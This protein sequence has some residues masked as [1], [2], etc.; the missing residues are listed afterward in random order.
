MNIL[1]YASPVGIRPS[2]KWAL[3]LYKQTE[4]YSNFNETGEG[5]LMLL[6]RKHS[7]LVHVLGGQ[8]S[9]DV[10]KR[11][12]C[13]DLGFKWGRVGPDLV[14]SGCSP[15]LE[16]LPDCAV[17]YR[18]V[19]CEPMIDAGDHDVVIV[20]IEGIWEPE[21]DGGEEGDMRHMYT[22]F[23]RENNI[24]SSAGRANPKEEQVQ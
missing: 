8:S 10:D 24:I 4:T 13:E 6:R 18:V 21:G 20:R 3:S 1:T 14:K 17:Y 15:Y 7:K 5:V 9:R 23:L 11:R 12:E 16:L 2:R 22:G 19:R